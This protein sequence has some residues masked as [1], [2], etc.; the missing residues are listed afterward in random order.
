MQLENCSS[1]TV[2]FFLVSKKHYCHAAIIFVLVPLLAR[3][4]IIVNLKFYLLIAGIII[5]FSFAEVQV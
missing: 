1:M 2:I 3:L 4:E 5:R